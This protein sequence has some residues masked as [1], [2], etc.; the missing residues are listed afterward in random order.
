VIYIITLLPSLADLSGAFDVPTPKCPPD[1]GSSEWV[2]DIRAPTYPSPPS[3]TNPSQ[4]A[5]PKRDYFEKP[6]LAYPPTPPLEHNHNHD[7]SDPIDKFRLPAPASA[8]VPQAI[9]PKINKDTGLATPPMTPEQAKEGD[10]SVSAISAKQTKSTLDFLTTLFPRSGLSAL[11]H[12]KGVSVSTPTLGTAFDGVVL[13]LPGKPKT[14]YVDGQ[15][16]ANVNL[17]E[18]IVALLDLADERLQC[19]A[20]VIALE[21]STDGLGELLHSLMYVG[22]T[23]VTTPP[24]PIEPTYILVGLEI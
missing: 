21:K 2:T 9:K 10:G 18:S 22:A 1:R 13:E 17:R 24:F 6:S 11:P 3:D 19:R 14:L 4:P 23:V 20:L 5:S 16:A 8:A 15:N 7:L 12:A